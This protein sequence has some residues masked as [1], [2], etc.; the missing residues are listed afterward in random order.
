[1]EHLI[2]KMQISQPMACRITGL[3][4]TAF[5]RTPVGQTTADPDQ[6]LRAW[7][8]QYAKDHPRWGYRRAYHDARA[9]GWLV[10]HKKLQRLWAEEG[11]RVPQRRRRKRVGS[12]TAQAPTAAAP[13]V[14]WAVDF[15]FDS[16]SRGRAIKICS[17]VDEHTR[18]NIG[19]L[20]ERSITADRFIALLDQIVAKRGYPA[21]LRSD[22]GPEFISHAMADW[23]GTKTGLFYIPPGSPW[24]NGYVESF[25]ARVRDECLNLHDFYSLLHAQVVIG[26]WRQEYN[27]RRRHSS[28]GY[29][30]P[31]DYARQCTC[32][33]E[34]DDSHNKRYY[35]RGR[36]KA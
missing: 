12:S 2:S 28:L 3:S 35:Q 15:Q 32:K 14:V 25:N 7:L 9:E 22:N 11:L 27:T 8:R 17:V 5:R 23:A 4:R 1:M 10:N 34:T 33:L 13:N 18:E 19:G 16:D 30:T 31:A 6:D 20:V 24:C 29:R 21:V 36:T 26:D